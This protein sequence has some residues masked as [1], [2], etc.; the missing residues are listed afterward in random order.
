[1]IYLYIKTHNQTGLKY[2]GKTTR[3]PFKYNGSGK[4]WKR[5]LEKHGNDVSTQVIAEFDDADQC[6]QFA[7]SFSKENRIVESE[8]WANFREEQLS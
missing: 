4:Y 7:L 1:M 3:D 6:T 5:H 2:F 8:D